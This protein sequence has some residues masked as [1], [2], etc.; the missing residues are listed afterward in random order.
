M[1]VKLSKAG[2]LRRIPG[3]VSENLQFGLDPAATT[4]NCGEVVCGA[5]SSL[6][7]G[8]S[9]EDI[10]VSGA[11]LGATLFGVDRLSLAG[12]AE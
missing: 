4:G 5:T 10:A 9:D 7:H 6:V 2:R 8:I 12:D 1:Y 11:G 3:G